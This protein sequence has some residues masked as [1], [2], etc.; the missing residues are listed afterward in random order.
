MLSPDRLLGGLPLS[1]VDGSTM[2]TKVLVP[3][4]VVGKTMYV[5]VLEGLGQS[6]V[7]PIAH[8]GNVGILEF[9][10]RRGQGGS[11]GGACG[12][13]RICQVLG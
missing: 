7:I 13:V 6:L 4:V 10:E 11:G 9:R 2:A 8:R 5:E 12:G 3:M 1:G